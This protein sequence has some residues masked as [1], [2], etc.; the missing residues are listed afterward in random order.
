MMLCMCVIFVTTGGHENI[1]V[2]TYQSGLVGCIRQLVINDEA[3]DLDDISI[4][5]SSSNV[6]DCNSS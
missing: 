5:A 4:I 2:T 6:I 1:A 3:I